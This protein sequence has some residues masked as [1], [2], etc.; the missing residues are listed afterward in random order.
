MKPR[1]KVL[2][3]RYPKC[4]WSRDRS[5]N[6]FEVEM[7]LPICGFNVFRSISDCRRAVFVAI[8]SLPLL[9][10]VGCLSAI[11]PNPSNSATKVSPTASIRVRPEN[12]TEAP[13]TRVQFVAL[14]RNT[15]D[16]SVNWSANGGAISNTGV[17]TVP[18][19]KAGTVFQIAATS[20]A[21]QGVTTVAIASPSS[22]GIPSGSGSGPGSGSSSSPSGA[23]NRYC[24]AGDVPN[25]GSADG[26]ASPPTACYQTS[27]AST[28]SA[29]AVI[30]V[31][32]NS[33]LQTAIDNAICG[34]TLVLQ[35]GNSYSG[36]SLP[37]KNCDAGRYIT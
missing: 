11:A 19:G 33:N 5:K 16:T 22:N 7:T 10:T 24:A 34:D 20:R 3:S 36:F 28:P 9:A 14:V 6:S 4:F 27:Q 8:I 12:P 15:R 25:F 26:P 21:A 29:G 18:N 37:A 1:I 2:S 17:F 32:P 30:Q 23:D 31:A 13:G 35:A